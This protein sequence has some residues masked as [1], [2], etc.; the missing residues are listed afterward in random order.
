MRGGDIV[1]NVRTGEFRIVVAY[2]KSRKEITFVRDNK[3][4]SA[5]DWVSSLA[6]NQKE[7]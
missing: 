2:D 1:F 3:W 7:D 6:I 4:Y 5:S